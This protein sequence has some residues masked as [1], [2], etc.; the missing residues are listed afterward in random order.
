[1]IDNAF[2]GTVHTVRIDLEGPTPPSGSAEDAQRRQ[3]VFV[4]Q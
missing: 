1:V 2:A 4:S 3:R